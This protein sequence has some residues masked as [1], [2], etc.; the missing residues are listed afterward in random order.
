MQSESLDDRIG[1]LEER[2]K[3]AGLGEGL[4]KSLSGQI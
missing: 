2:L 3:D 1:H 4:R